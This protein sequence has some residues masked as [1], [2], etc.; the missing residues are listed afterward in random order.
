[1]DVVDFTEKTVRLPT[2]KKCG[3]I[4]SIK[5]PTEA[6]KFSEGGILLY[7]IPKGERTCDHIRII[8]IDRK[9]DYRT[10]YEIAYTARK[11]IGV[12][13]KTIKVRCPIC[14]AKGNISIP[15]L[16]LQ[17]SRVKLQIEVPLDIVCSHYFIMF[18]RKNKK[19]II[20]ILGYD[21]IK[22]ELIELLQKLNK[23]LV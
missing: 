17:G 21:K 14:Q 12:D 13:N 16:L 8:T 11:V 3:K 4:G 23:V 18:I 9:F 10:Q 19:E 1:M 2:C 6:F 22:P 15:S 7:P 20:E 5:V